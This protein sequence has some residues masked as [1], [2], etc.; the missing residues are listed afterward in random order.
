MLWWFKDQMIETTKKIKI[1]K[2][3]TKISI[4]M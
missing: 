2:I 1:K 3:M 4:I